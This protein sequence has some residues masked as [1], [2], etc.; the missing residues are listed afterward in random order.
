MSLKSHR[1][2]FSCTLIEQWTLNCSNM[3][4]TGFPMR[5]YPLFLCH[6]FFIP[7]ARSVKKTLNPLP[8]RVGVIFESP[9]TDEPRW[10]YHRHFSFLKTSKWRTLSFP[11]LLENSH[12]SV[13]GPHRILWYSNRGYMGFSHKFLGLLRTNHTESFWSCDS[14]IHILKTLLIK[15]LQGSP[16]FTHYYTQLFK[17]FKS[18]YRII[19]Q[20]FNGS[21][22]FM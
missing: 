13:S 9:V 14:Y 3:T 2:Y 8:G 7:I 21:Y 5:Q 22:H 10:F 12:R 19:S 17:I 1:F 4:S 11:L 15:S 20:N 18:F 6:A 16:S